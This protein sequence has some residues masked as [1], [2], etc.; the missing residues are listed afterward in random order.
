MIVSMLIVDSIVDD[1][2]PLVLSILGVLDTL[3]LLEDDS[4]LWLGLE[5]V[6]LVLLVV[7]AVA[8][9]LDDALLAGGLDH[10]AAA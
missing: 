7:L 1:P 2:L 3:V 4:V 6:A 10:V 9:E 5:R 8:R